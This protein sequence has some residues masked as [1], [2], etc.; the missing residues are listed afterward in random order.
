MEDQRFYLNGRDAMRRML[1]PVALVYVVMF[2]P[3]AILIFLM[4][5]VSD[6]EGL[7]A[8]VAVLVA[9][10]LSLIIVFLLTKHMEDAGVLVSDDGIV[11]QGPNWPNL[12]IRPEDV[13]AIT[14]SPIRLADYFGSFWPPWSLTLVNLLW[15]STR[16][17]RLTLRNKRKFP[18]VPF[19]RIQTILLDPEDRR[20]FLEAL[21]RVAPHVT[22]DSALVE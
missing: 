18:Y 16:A 15:P 8:P 6:P 21:Q 7:A 4:G 14:G 13:S 1:W 20:G 17:L 5:D 2:I 9:L 11:L 12:R 3:I 10:P 19:L 22:I